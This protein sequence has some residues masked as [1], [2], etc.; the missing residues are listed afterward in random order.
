MDSELA[1]ALTQLR[2]DIVSDVDH[3]L[4]ERIT[5]F[6]NDMLSHFDAIYQKLDRLETEYQAIKA[7]VIRLE[8]RMERIEET[9]KSELRQ[10]LS[11]IK[12]RIVQLQE[13]VAELEAEL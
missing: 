7:A 10:E 3:M 8:K 1:E 13:R 6:R 4:D 11:E 5:P 2:N 9:L 12:V